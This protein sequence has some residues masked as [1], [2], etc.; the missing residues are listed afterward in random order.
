MVGCRSCLG[1]SITTNGGGR[2]VSKQTVNFFSMSEGWAG[3]TKPRHP[4]FCSTKLST[5]PWRTNLYKTF[6]H[7]HSKYLSLIISI[8]DL[9]LLLSSL[10]LSLIPARR[11]SHSIS[12][13]YYY[14]LI[15][16]FHPSI[17]HPTQIFKMQYSSAV[18]I[19]AFAATNV[20]AHGVIDSVKGANSVTMPALSGM[21]NSSHP[22]LI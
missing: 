17:L 5:K 8:S 14:H 10:L 7:S 9:Q 15:L 4:V 13:F 21:L 22:H 3:C 6:F 16:A 12:N 1:P 18:L 11:R 20:F 2:E 19:A